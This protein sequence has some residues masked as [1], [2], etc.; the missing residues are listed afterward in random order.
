MSMIITPEKNIMLLGVS[1]STIDSPLT[2]SPASIST[3]LRILAVL[4]FMKT[5]PFITLAFISFV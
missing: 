2:H 1:H 4:Y 5:P 3:N